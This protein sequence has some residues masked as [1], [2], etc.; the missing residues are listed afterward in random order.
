MSETKP[1][2]KFCCSDYCIYGRTTRARYRESELHRSAASNAAAG[3]VNEFQHSTCL[4]QPVSR[5]RQGLALSIMDD[6]SVTV[7]GRLDVGDGRVY[8]AA[9]GV[10]GPAASSHL[11]ESLR[12][13]SGRMANP[14]GSS[15][16][17]AGSSLLITRFT[18]RMS[19]GANTTM[20]PDGSTQLSCST[21]CARSR[22]GP[23]NLH[24]QDKETRKQL[25][26]MLDI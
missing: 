5:S 6:S 25:N 19:M 26:T 2:H 1:K 18:A 14:V 12:P 9:D 16:M 23:V 8:E 20:D 3:G 22:S 24:V 13:S 17:F 7:E 4:N 11:A 10:Q 15:W 21:C